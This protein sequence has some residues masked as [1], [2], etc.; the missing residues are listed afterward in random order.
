LVDGD[1]EALFQSCFLVRLYS[2]RVV[3]QCDGP[4]R[5]CWRGQLAKVACFIAVNNV[6]NV[7]GGGWTALHWSANS[8]NVDCVKYCLKMGANVNARTN[9]G[10]TPLHRAS[11]DGHVNVVCVLLDAG[12]IVDE[13]KVMDG[14]HYIMLFA[15]NMLMLHILL[16]IGEQTC[17]TLNW[18]SMYQ[19]SLIGSPHLLNRDPNVDLLQLSSSGYTST[20][21]QQ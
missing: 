7:D 5:C 6:N 12:A 1:E 13:K 8:R 19:Q 17:Q 16:L 10:S 2:H 14:H 21:E 18:T 11:W 15:T 20:I 3:K 4:V 9:S